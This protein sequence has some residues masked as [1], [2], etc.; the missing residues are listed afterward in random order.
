MGPLDKLVCRDCRHDKRSLDEGGMWG[1]EEGERML[2][3]GRLRR[4]SHGV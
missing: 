1:H 3:N 4:R 2:N